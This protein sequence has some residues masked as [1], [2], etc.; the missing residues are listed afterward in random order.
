MTQHCWALARGRMYKQPLPS[1]PIRDSLLTALWRRLYPHE[2]LHISSV[3][4]STA[5]HARI[6]GESAP[7]HAA[8]L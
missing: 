5:R 1:N 3:G 6:H 2:L 8:P 7:I 4:G